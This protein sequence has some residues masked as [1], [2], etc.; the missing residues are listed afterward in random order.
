MLDNCVY[1]N[2]KSAYNLNNSDILIPQ[3]KAKRHRVQKDNAVQQHCR[4]WNCPM[5]SKLVIF[6]A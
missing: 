1:E 4:N 2:T 3:N 6:Y 5:T